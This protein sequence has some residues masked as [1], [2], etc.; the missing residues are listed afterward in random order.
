M[1][2]E[3]KEPSEA[4][5]FRDRLT[6]AVFLLF[7]AS[8]PLQGTPTVD[9]G[10]T[11]QPCYPLLALLVMLT[12]AGAWIDRD[13]SFLRSPVTRP[14][15]LLWGVAALSLVMTFA[16]P[17]PALEGFNP[18]QGR[19]S[20]S[21]RSFVQFGLLLFFSS[22]FFVTLRCC[23]T[24]ERRRAVLWTWL[25]AS[26]VESLYAFYQLAAIQYGLPGVNGITSIEAAGGG[27]GIYYHDDPARFRS[28]GTF[29]EPSFLAHY[30]LAALPA[31]M[32]W[33]SRRASGVLLMTALLLTQTRGALVAFAAGLWILFRSLE[34]RPRLKMLGMLG[35][36][37]GVFLV[38]TV[39][40]RGIRT[41]REFL[42][43][44][45]VTASR[46]ELNRQMKRGPDDSVLE[47]HLSG[48]ERIAFVRFTAGFLARH[49]E[50]WLLGTGIGNY[51]LHGTVESGMKK[52]FMN[53][54]SLPLQAL[55]D[56]GVVGFSALVFFLVVLFR[57]LA[58][59][60]RTA[61]DSDHR[62]WMT[63]LLAALA[64]LFLYDLVHH[65]RILIYVWVLVGLAMASLR[66]Q[67]ATPSPR[68]T[69]P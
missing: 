30:L 66:T 28:F 65:I 37:L 61:E 59:E 47:R 18:V 27:Y 22:S 40:V 39:T 64:A 68:K 2:T 35:A 31:A 45:A 5:S 53:A 58:R 33:S 6:F 29:Q 69:Q 38:V 13:W 36:T 20:G 51:A 54:Q 60:V 55:V 52:T 67:I 16:C 46:G 56:T 63:V 3:S 7:V 10:Y 14:I 4:G 50:F 24:P 57:T 8:F 11:I 12:A 1:N 62:L 43:S 23:R 19:R 34:R 15:L 26:S 32:A 9:V 21:G 41:L 17:P 48:D 49:P 42:E 44:S 25:A